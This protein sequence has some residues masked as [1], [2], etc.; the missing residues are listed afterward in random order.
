MKI[1]FNKLKK[2]SK[3]LKAL[4]TISLLCYM[5][6]LVLFTM[7]ILSLAGI[8]T[9]IRI[10]ALVIFYL[11]L[12]GYLIGGL[13]ALIAKKKKTLIFLSIIV[14]LLSAI[15]GFASYYI[16]KT[17]NKID[18]I[19]KK[20]VTYTS[21]MI[22]MKDTDEDDIEDIGIISNQEDIE[23]Y[24]LAQEIIKKENIDK[25]SLVEYDDYFEM[26]TDMYAGDIDAAFVTSNYAVSFATEEL[27]ANMSEDVK[28]VYE[29]SK[30]MKNQDNV[31][32]A[33]SGKKLTEPFTILLLGVDSEKDGLNA[34]QAFNGDTLMMITFNPNTMNAT[35]FS[36]PRDTY[37][38]IAC[39]GGK[40]NK[41]NSSAAYGTKCVIDTIE[42][43]TDIDID[44]YVKVN[45]KGV[46]DLVNALDGVEVDVPVSFCEQD[47]N[48]LFG[49]NEICLKPGVQTL[50][51]EQALALS[52][53][54]KT[55]PLGDFQR[56]QH[57]QLVV[58]GIAKKAKTIRD[59]DEFYEILDA[60]SKNI[61]TNMSTNQMLSFYNVL[62]KML[63]T[64]LTEDDEFITIDKAY[65]TGNDLS[66]YSPT[67]GRAT[68]TF[69]Y[70]RN[71]L[72]EIVSMM[73]INLELEE[74]EM[75]T[76]FDFSINE[77]YEQ[78]VAG[79]NVTGGNYVPEGALTA[80]PVNDKDDDDDTT[81]S[82]K[83]M[84]NLVNK[85]LSYAQSW[86]NSSNIK[87]TI[88]YITEKDS[89]YNSSYS[90][91]TIVTQSVSSGSDLKNITTV[92]ISV[93]KKDSSSSSSNNPAPTDPDIEDPDNNNPG[94]NTGGG[95]NTGDGGDITTDPDNPA[96]TIPGGP[97]ND[98]G[99]N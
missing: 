53:H 19:S 10:T 55:L 16:N 46:V 70:N 35:M 82:S 42:D 18:T 36:I 23:G 60:V 37:V 32:I 15:F 75:I 95:E 92:V 52:R 80:P 39:R 50:D 17:Y 9:A 27:F 26:L 7:N 86:A 74:P 78:D 66:I 81:T 69:Q 96:T 4:F 61:D 28:V 38:P 93:I 49:A 43:L 40:E 3:P 73:K 90:D 68:Y 56:V 88:N 20:Y 8:E 47:S 64:T 24:I 41:I 65:L 63:T 98:G 13:V 91:G 29:F 59:V 58:E 1:L 48:R 5:V 14:L 79:K 30:K 77:K 2:C 34:N 12:I 71:S 33:S 76:S 31:D 97:T 57:Q 25:D 54:R 6:T 21:N 72:K 87:L 99:S 94:G 45:F 11:L 51:G 22:A 89:L 44:Y 83:S 67:T 62:K 84:P 85:S